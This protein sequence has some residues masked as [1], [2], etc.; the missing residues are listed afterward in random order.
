MQAMRP[1]REIGA[2]L[3]RTALKTSLFDLRR[4]ASCG[5]HQIGMPAGIGS[6]QV[7][8]I[9][10]GCMAG[11]IGIRRDDRLESMAVVWVARQPHDIG[12]EMAAL[13]TMQ[14]R[15]DRGLHVELM[16]TMRLPRA[17]TFDLLRMQGIDLLAAS[18]TALTVAHMNPRDETPGP[19]RRWATR[20][21]HLRP[22]C[23]NSSSTVRARGPIWPSMPQG[24]IVQ[25][26]TE[27]FEAY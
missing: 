18:R 19:P 23:S 10:L 15:G 13:Q 21:G 3:T 20:L 11:F 27:T 26:A 22:P 12:D 6:E 1:A 2:H 17:D 5:R 4:R 24:K 7:A 16:G 14:R 25:F 9:I 8:R